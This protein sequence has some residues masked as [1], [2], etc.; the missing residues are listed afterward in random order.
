MVNLLAVFGRF[1]VL[2][3]I[4]FGSVPPQR[5]PD[6]TGHHC[7]AKTGPH[8]ERMVRVIFADS[9]RML[10]T[11]TVDGLVTEDSATPV[12]RR[13]LALMYAERYAQLL[14]EAWQP[15]VIAPPHP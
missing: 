2:R 5:E 8:G 4:A 7:F 15:D 9:D 14:S 12:G 1:P 13:D 11:A 10:E 6:V 3:A